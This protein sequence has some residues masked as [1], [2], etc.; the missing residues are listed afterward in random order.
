MPRNHWHSSV[1]AAVALAC[2]AALAHADRPTNPGGGGGAGGGPENAVLYGDLYVIERDGNGI[3]I[4]RSFEIAGEG[5]IEVVACVQP[6]AANCRLLGLMGDAPDFDPAEDDACDVQPAEVEFLQEVSFGRQSVA[7]AAPT[8]V[9]SAY[10]D[11]LRNLN[12]ATALRLDPAGRLVLTLPDE[13]TG[14]PVEKTIDAPLENL[15]LY[16]AAMKDGCLGPVT[17]EKEPEVPLTMEL[18]AAAEVL[19]RAKLLGHLVCDEAG[20]PLGEPGQLDLFRAAAFYAGAADKSDTVRL[21]EIVNVNTYLGVNSVTTG[22]SGR[23]RGNVIVTYFEFEQ[24]GTTFTYDRGHTHP[25][26]PGGGD[27]LELPVTEYLLTTPDGG[28]TFVPAYLALFEAAPPGVD[29]ASVNVMLCRDGLPYV[30]SASPSELLYCNDQ[31]DV[32]GEC[33]GANWFTQATEDA[34]KVVWFLHN[35]SAP[36]LAW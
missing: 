11:A 21:D 22:T 25:G 20:E 6:I 14:L 33:G 34:R 9:D 5:G 26:T 2:V 3:P 27:A 13:L 30:S 23:D 4:T 31:A 10:Y 29:L 17:I 36:E 8:V 15:G 19:L 16:R 12:T 24:G 32:G 18:G 1:F 7:R 28:L 35:W